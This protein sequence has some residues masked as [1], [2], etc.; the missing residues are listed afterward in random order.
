MLNKTNIWICLFPYYIEGEKHHVTHE[1]YVWVSIYKIKGEK[2]LDDL[3]LAQ[4]IWSLI[5]KSEFHS[6]DTFILC[7]IQ[8]TQSLF[9]SN[10]VVLHT[11]TVYNFRFF[12][13]ERYQP[14]WLY[15]ESLIVNFILKNKN[16]LLESMVPWRN[17]NIHG[18]F[19][20]HKKFFRILQ[21]SSH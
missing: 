6:Y 18:T 17:Y 9:L 4:I 3:L 12:K 20:L 16:Y 1:Y 2:S 11:Q 14:L 15:H 8:G 13:M 19:P 7:R 21:S 5:L 10:V